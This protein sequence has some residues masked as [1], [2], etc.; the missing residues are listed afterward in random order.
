M[1]SHPSFC[2]DAINR[3][4]TEPFRV[5]PFPLSMLRQVSAT[6]TGVK[7]FIKGQHADNFM[8]TNLKILTQAIA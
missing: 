8:I 6:K 3:V 7:P 5:R 4:S 2:L 1:P